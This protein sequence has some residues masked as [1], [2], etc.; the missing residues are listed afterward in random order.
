MGYA[1]ICSLNC[2]SKTKGGS[3]LS[4]AN[5]RIPIHIIHSTDWVSVNSSL[6]IFIDPQGFLQYCYFFILC[7]TCGL[8][9]GLLRAVQN[10]KE[11]RGISV[12]VE[13]AER[14]VRGRGVLRIE[15]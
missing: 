8:P 10:F 7:G 5:I 3:E 15:L 13:E 2:D 1:D 12:K 11:N 9:E 6:Y 4:E 14:F